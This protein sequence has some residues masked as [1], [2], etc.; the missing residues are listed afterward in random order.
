[1][2]TQT[3]K[4]ALKTNPSLLFAY[5]KIEETKLANELQK[6]NYNFPDE[7]IGFWK[8]FGGGDLFET[9]TIL[10]PLQSTNELV[11]SLVPTNDFYHTN[12][13]DNKY[14]IFQKNAAQLTVFD[15]QTD[16]IVLLSTG[17]YVVRKRFENFENWFD[18]FWKVNS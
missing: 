9:E 6:I 2:I 3:V 15:S 4:E 10:Y 12:G 1:M 7:L 13:L 5:G 16:E 14:I 17:N 8:E 11:D 18:Y